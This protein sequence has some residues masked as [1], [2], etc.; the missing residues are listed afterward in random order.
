MISLAKKRDTFLAGLD[1]KLD[2]LLTGME[3]IREMLENFLSLTP[4]E[5]EIQLE[6]VK[7]HAIQLETPVFK[8]R[9][10]PSLVKTIKGLHERGPS[11]IEDIAAH[12]GKSRNVLS[13]YLKELERLGYVDRLPNL[14]EKTTARYIFHLRYDRLP[15]E[16]QDLIGKKTKR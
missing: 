3:Q 11:G 7:R 16:V 9:L 2:T 1:K 6:D 15:S 10:T 8:S 13:G 14:D 12:M 5:L 4:K